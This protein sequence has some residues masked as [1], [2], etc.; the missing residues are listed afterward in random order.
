MVPT[1]WGLS[2]S[3]ELTDQEGRTER[4]FTLLSMGQEGTWELPLK[5]HSRGQLCIL[6]RAACLFGGLRPPGLT[7]ITLPTLGAGP[8]SGSC[9]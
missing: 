1:L 4:K 9:P 8:G 2:M 7:T 3:V 5:A 6:S